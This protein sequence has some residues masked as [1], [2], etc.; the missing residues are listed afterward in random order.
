MH[1]IEKEM[2]EREIQLLSIVDGSSLRVINKMMRERDD[3][4]LYPINGAFNATERAIRWFRRVYFPS[5]GPCSNLEY[6]LG[7]ELKIIEYVNSSV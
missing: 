6:A 4:H 7:L 2:E 5:N 1:P 3:S